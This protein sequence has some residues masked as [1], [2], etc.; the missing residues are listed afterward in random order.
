MGYFPSL[1][2]EFGSNSPVAFFQ[3][4]C[5]NLVTSLASNAKPMYSLS[6][7]ELPSGVVSK[8][9]PG[10]DIVSLHLRMCCEGNTP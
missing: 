7:T 8:K 6:I 3:N 2:G 5:E 4:N 1:S 10:L 9:F